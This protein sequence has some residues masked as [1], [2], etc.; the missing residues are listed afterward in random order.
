MRNPIV[1]AYDKVKLELVWQTATGEIPQLRQAL[2]PLIP[3]QN[4]ALS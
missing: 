3:P 2:E 4:S 1:H